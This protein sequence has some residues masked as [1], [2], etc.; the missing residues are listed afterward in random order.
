[1]AKIK[2]NRLIGLSH[3][4]DLIVTNQSKPRQEPAVSILKQKV[5]LISGR[6]N[7]AQHHG[8]KLTCTFL[9]F[10]RSCKVQSSLKITSC[11]IHIL[12]W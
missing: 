1:M 6:E 11:R 9:C 2:T 5:F 4:C 12:Y 3:L 10:Y 8:N 7:S